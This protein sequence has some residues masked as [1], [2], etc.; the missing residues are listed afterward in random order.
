MA[1]GLVG[2]HLL[3]PGRVTPG[4]ASARRGSD[5]NAPKYCPQWRFAASISSYGPYS[6]L[7]R[8]P[9]SALR[10][11]ARPLA[12]SLRGSLFDPVAQ[13]AAGWSHRGQGQLG[14]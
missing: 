9:A 14:F 10:L 11:S 4:N 6:C 3:T 2:C 12:A 5:E 1:S 13:P 8:G 7:L